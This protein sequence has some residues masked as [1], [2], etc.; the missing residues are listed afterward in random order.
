MEK[1]KKKKKERPGESSPTSDS[2]AYGKIW[3]VGE[4]EIRRSTP[5]LPGALPGEKEEG[6]KGRKNTRQR[7][8]TS[9][10]KTAGKIGDIALCI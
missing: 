5:C 1:E 2:E 3:G 10:A 9:P 4:K 7:S 6:K 8:I